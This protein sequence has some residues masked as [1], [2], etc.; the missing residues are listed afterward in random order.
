M[1]FNLIVMELKKL[2]KENWISLVAII[3]ISLFFVL[4]IIPILSFIVETKILEKSEDLIKVDT[5][6]IT[7]GINCLI[8]FILLITW[9]DLSLYLQRY[10]RTRGLKVSVLLSLEYII[11][12]LVFSLALFLIFQNEYLPNELTRNVGLFY[13]NII[14]VLCWF[15][16]ACIFKKKQTPLKRKEINPLSDEPI[17]YIEQDKLD[18]KKFVEDLFDSIVKLPFSDPF[19]FG[20]F[21]GWGQ[22]KSSILRI[23]R[24]KL[25]ENEDMILIEF[26][27][28][29]FKDHDAIVRAF[30]NKIE[31]SISK[32]FIF[33]AGKRTLMKY[34]KIILKGISSKWIN[35]HA[36]SESIEEVKEKIQSYLKTIDKRLIFLI[37]EVDRLHPDEILPFFRLLRQNTNFYNSIFILSFDDKV[38]RNYIKD[39]LHADPEFLNKIIQRPITLPYVDQVH[40]DRFFDE[41]IEEFFNEIGL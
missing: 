26:E 18:R 15:C 23:L 22:G 27:P 13:L 4:S 11:L 33:P 30:Y 21:G 7:I 25:K 1:V 39:I 8:L 3:L 32:K 20:I 37:D 34:Q 9:E 31:R 35:I 17:E 12:F 28:W 5:F 10:K 16:S 6:K 40:I 38:I 14:F 36:D 29:N 24:N 41:R 2:V 19:V